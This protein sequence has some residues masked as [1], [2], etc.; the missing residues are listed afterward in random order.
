MNIIDCGYF[1][2]YTLPG[3]IEWDVI[4]NWDTPLHRDID[5][6]S[7]DKLNAIVAEKDGLI[8]GEK[9]LEAI[10]Q[11]KRVL[12]SGYGEQD[13][14]TALNCNLGVFLNH[15]KFPD[16]SFK[17]VPRT[18]KLEIEVPAP[19][20]PKIG[21]KYWYLSNATRQGYEFNIYN[22]FECDDRAMNFGAYRTEEDVKKVVEQLRK[23]KAQ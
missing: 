8:S 7:L 9:A 6:L 13:W 22:N 1:V 12:Y 18:I 23:I 17:I 21:E 15:D 19:F 5:V 11:G 20:E 2:A 10:Q 3:K 14:D 4:E 16:F